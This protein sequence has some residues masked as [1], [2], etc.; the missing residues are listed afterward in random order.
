MTT[1][2]TTGNLS[3][4][5]TPTIQDSLPRHDFPFRHPATDTTTVP[6]NTS[7]FSANLVIGSSIS[8]TVYNDSNHDSLQQLGEPGLSGWTVDLINSVA[9]VVQQV[10]VTN[11]TY[12]FTGVSPGTYTVA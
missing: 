11:G 7:E 10:T 2:A 8:G 6:G 3:F 9:T 12:S 4:S 1:D 5:F